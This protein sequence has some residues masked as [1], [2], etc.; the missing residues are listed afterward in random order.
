MMGLAAAGCTIPGL[1]DG[2]IP[3]GPIGSSFSTATLLKL[4]AEGKAKVGSALTGS[5]IDVYDL[6]PVSLGDRIIVTITPVAGSPLDPI[7]A[8]FDA[9][10]EL[11]ALNDDVDYPTRIDSAI[12][13]VVAVDSPRY[14]LGVS[15]YQDT[16]SYEGTVQI[17]R[18][19]GAAAPQAQYVLLNFNGGTV[20]IP[21]EGGPITVGAFNAADVDAVYGG[22]TAAIKAKIAEVVRQNYAAFHIQIVTSDEPPPPG[23]CKSVIYFGGSNDL[24]FGVAESVDQGNRDRCD[25][26]IVFTNGFDDP[27]FPQPTVDGIG[28]AI[29]N[30]AAHEMGHLLGLNHVADVADLMDSTGTASTL[31]V[32]QEFKTS[33][34]VN[35][36]F[37]TGKQNGPAMLRRV[38]PP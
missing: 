36:I 12:D 5:K 32:D 3:A 14:Y 17:L 10:E 33:V 13:D 26:G 23:D 34:L 4:D 16:G 24:K 6:G 27:F 35:Q 18:G 38:L 20:N 25:D 1:P 15:K 21:S 31:L 7:A 19:Q 9:N 28:I 29:G 37:P 11:F 30:V 8:I 22:A 2:S